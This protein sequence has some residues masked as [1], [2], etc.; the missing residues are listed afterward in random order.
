MTDFHPFDVVLL[1]IEGTTTPISFVYDVLF[2]YARKALEGYVHDHW[3]SLDEVVEQVITDTQN[4]EDIPTLT[5]PVTAQQVVDSLLWQMN[6]DKKT[7]GLKQL[8]GKI[9]RA[10]YVDGTLK[11]EVFDDVEP[12]FEQW[13]AQGVEIYI[14]SSGSVAA[15]KLLFGYSTQGDLTTALKGYFD[16]TTGPKKQAHSYTLIASQLGVMAKRMCF[17]TDNMDEARAA[18][19]AGMQVLVMT[20]PGNPVVDTQDFHTADDFAPLLG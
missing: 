9:W 12:A 11:G 8:Q 16:T 14:Y 10:G 19:E 17:A 1:D 2:P 20:R 15:Q 5:K 3:A 7:T 6:N 4:D 18:R 13:H